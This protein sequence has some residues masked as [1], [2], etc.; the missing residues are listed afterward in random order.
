MSMNRKNF[1]NILF[2]FSFS[3][4]I[5]TRV[6]GLI[7]GLAI[8]FIGI[9]MLFII[10]AGFNNG[11]FSGLG[12]LILAPI[13]GLIYLL[14]VRVGLESLIAGIKTAENTSQI[15]NYIKQFRENDSV[16]PGSE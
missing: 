2:D 8:F 3:S 11:F 6:V 12:S 7:Y 10:G 15:K 5:A 13:I 16:N 1:F 14:F 9:L 4:F